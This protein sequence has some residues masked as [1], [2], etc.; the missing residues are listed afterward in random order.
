[1]S[2]LASLALCAMLP[3][4]APGAPARSQTT[5]TSTGSVGCAMITQAAANETSVNSRARSAPLQYGLE[6]SASQK[7]WVSKL[8]STRSATYFTSAAGI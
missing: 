5:T 1:M 8:A 4:L 2:R 6:V 7:M 3:A